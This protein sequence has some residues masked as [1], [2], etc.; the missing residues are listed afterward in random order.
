[1][2][3][4]RSGVE[5]ALAPHVVAFSPDDI[6]ARKAATH[7]H[8]STTQVP[9]LRAFGFALLSIVVSAHTLATG[10]ASW[11]QVGR[12]VVAFAAYSLG[13][14]LVLR[15][16]HHR[17][18][19]DAITVFFVID[20]FVWMGAVRV[21]GG[22]ESWLCFLSLVRVA[23]QLHTNRARAMG[24]TVVAVLAY[25][26]LL[27]YLAV[28]D[29]E[30]VAWTRQVGRI[31]FLAACGSYLAATAGTAERLRANLSGA[32][33]A[34]RDSIRQ[35]RDQ[36]SL[37]Q[38]ALERAD[39]ANRAK[40]EFLANVSHEFR[41]PL[42]AI[43]GYAELLHEELEVGSPS[44]QEDLQRINRSAQH[45]RGLVNDVIELSRIEADRVSLD[46]QAFSVSAL[47]ADVVSVVL[48]VVHEHQNVLEVKGA[49]EA[50]MM[51]AD[52]AKIRQILVNL[53][54]N[55]GKFTADGAIALTCLREV[56]T[57]PDA[58]L[59]RVSDT[60]VGMH[61]EQL[62][63]IRRFEPFVQADA[64]A[65]R[66]YAGTGLGLAISHRLCALMGGTL[67]VDSEAGR[68]TIVTARLPA[69]MGEPLP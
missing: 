9:V 50:G 46:V 12:M 17:S 25:I 59:F 27:G 36:S 40:S 26:G 20:P 47:V 32:V 63:R 51:V 68:G 16:W 4:R 45:L 58:V 60:G 13:S 43:I 31:L 30:R 49:A 24:F 65:T 34:A 44:A 6:R 33:R 1:M 18:P 57:G 29:G 41:T 3:P 67:T 53:L 39:A 15:W 14:W 52:Q 54:G 42:N 48:P 23:D 28:V 7:R 61:P 10:E 22:A 8:Y 62:A 21:T 19:V 37:L 35:L 38:D 55:A 66:R 5:E 64:S 2:S 69:L 11:P 56:S